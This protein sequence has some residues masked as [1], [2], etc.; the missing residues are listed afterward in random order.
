Y[1]VTGSQPTPGAAASRADGA[2]VDFAAIARA[3]G[4]RSV[5]AFEDAAA[6]KQSV[7]AVIEEPGPTFVH[8]AIQSTAA[9]EPPGFPGPSPARA[10][11]FRESLAAAVQAEGTT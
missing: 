8:L 5:Y 1:E 11:A 2:P 7:R 4:F 6:W 10:R 9:G 3:C